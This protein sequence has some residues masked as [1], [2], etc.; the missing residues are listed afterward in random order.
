M[1]DSD[2]IGLSQFILAKALNAFRISYLHVMRGDFAGQQQ[3]D[4][5][6][7]IRAE[8][9]GVLIGNMGYSG[10]EA[11]AAVRDGKLDA[12]AFGCRFWATP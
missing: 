7:P 1:K 6:T 10:E 9:K 12:V 3:G 2:P 4:V 5:L 8:Y 11:T